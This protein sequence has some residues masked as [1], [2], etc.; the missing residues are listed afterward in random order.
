MLRFA[1]LISVL[2]AFGCGSQKYGDCDSPKDDLIVVYKSKPSLP[3]GHSYC[4]VC[5]P[6]LLPSDYVDWALEMGAPQGP[7]DPSA[8]HPCLYAYSNG[9]E[10]V[11]LLT[12]ENLICSGNADYND[13][14]GKEQGNVDLG[15]ISAQ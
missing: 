1:G 5:N 3:I 2:L 7:T 8:V 15:S 10:I 12:C 4:I 9:S 14:V 11:D 13:M 6:D